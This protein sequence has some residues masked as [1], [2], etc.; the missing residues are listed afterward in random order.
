MDEERKPMG[1]IEWASQAGLSDP[2]DPR[3]RYRNDP[4]VARRTDDP[5][6]LYLVDPLAEGFDSPR[7]APQAEDPLAHRSAKMRCESCMYFV[8][9]QTAPVGVKPLVA[10]GRCRRHAPTMGGWPAVYGTDWCGD[11]KLDEAKA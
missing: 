1:P 7:V 10:F 9:K 5:P 2:N 6:A 3:K 8:E 11:H 4:T